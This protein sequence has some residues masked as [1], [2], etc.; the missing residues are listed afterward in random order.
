[1]RVEASK[2]KGSKEKVPDFRR[3]N[4]TKLRSTLN[5]SNWIKISNEVD[6]DKAWEAFTTELIN[7]VTQCVPFRDRRPATNKPKWWNSEIEKS[8]SLKKRAH[9]KYLSTRSQD[10]KLELDR[11][12]RETKKN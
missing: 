2:V 12:R 7:A 11:I 5:K 3:A 8:L 9:K 1:M 10:D 4:F 6:I